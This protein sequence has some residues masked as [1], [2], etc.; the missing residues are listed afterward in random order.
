MGMKAQLT[1]TIKNNGISMTTIAGGKDDIMVNRYI[2]GD[3]QNILEGTAS[4]DD[5]A[6]HVAYML[7]HGVEQAPFSS[8]SV[9]EMFMDPNIERIMLKIVTKEQNAEMLKNTPHRDIHGDLSIISVYRVSDEATCVIS[10]SISQ[11]MGLTPTE[12]LDY[13]IRNATHEE[14][15]VQGMG[16]MLAANMGMDPAQATEIFGTDE[17]MLV[18]TNA[19]KRFG[20]ADIFVDKSLRQQ[21]ADK[22]GDDYYIIPS[23]IHEVICVRSDSMEP[24]QAQMMIQEVN[25]TELRPEEILGSHPYLVDAETLKITNPCEVQ[26]QHAADEM[27]HSIHM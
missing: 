13:A 23:S 10:N 14:H 3:I 17:S 15:I 8:K 21:V 18:V 1:D 4:V 5:V 25:A 7:G 26:V 9:R 11:Q 27:R 20:A 22:L 12:L 19:D 24:Q 2:D 16:E 6:S